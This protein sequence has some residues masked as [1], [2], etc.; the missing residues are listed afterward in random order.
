V[1]DQ[2]AILDHVCRFC[3]GR[4]LQRKN[5][6]GE[7]IVRCADCDTEVTGRVEGL[8]ACGAKLRSGQLA[9]L[10]CKVNPNPTIAQPARVVVVFMGERK[11]V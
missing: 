11:A 5:D 7:S 10:A 9:G 2:W 1:S 4:L 3:Y 8:C 6:Q